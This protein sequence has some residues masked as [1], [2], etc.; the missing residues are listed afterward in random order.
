MWWGMSSEQ[1][2]KEMVCRAFPVAIGYLFSQ[3]RLHAA[4]SGEQSEDNAMCLSIPY[5]GLAAAL[6][7]H[8]S[9]CVLL[10]LGHGES[11]W[12]AGTAAL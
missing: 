11:S 3:T 5:W 6:G 12:L 7:C 10:P 1:Q 2:R 4:H 8:A 9:S